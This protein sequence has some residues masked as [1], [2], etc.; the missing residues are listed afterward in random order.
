[1]KSRIVTAKQ[2]S[3]K[4]HTYIANIEERN[5]NVLNVEHI[6]YGAGI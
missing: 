2:P 3:K 1:M 6:I 5:C 4:E